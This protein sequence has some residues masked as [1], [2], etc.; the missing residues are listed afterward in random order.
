MATTFAAH[1]YRQY[2]RDVRHRGAQIISPNTR[3][4]KPGTEFIY[5]GEKHDKRKL[6]TK[7]LS[8]QFIVGDVVAISQDSLQHMYPHLS[9]ANRMDRLQ[10][11][12]LKRGVSGLMVTDGE[13]GLSVQYHLGF[14]NRWEPHKFPAP[15]INGVKN[16]SRCWRCNRGWGNAG[17]VA[18]GDDEL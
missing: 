15:F 16:D 18:A 10:F 6:Y 7:K 1:E 8:E 3:E 9:E 17:D 4:I 11:D 5:R 12:T 2:T 14:R 13:N